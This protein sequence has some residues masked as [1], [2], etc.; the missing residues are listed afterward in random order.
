MQE[1][2]VLLCEMK[3]C[4]QKLL[5]GRPGLSESPVVSWRS[6]KK[7]SSNGFIFSIVAVTGIFFSC[8][9]ERARGIVGQLSDISSRARQ[10]LS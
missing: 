9:A 10:L 5:N 7:P 3:E 8:I 2:R 4:V 6:G 1:K